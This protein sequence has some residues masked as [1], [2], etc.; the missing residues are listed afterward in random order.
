MAPR[1]KAADEAATPIP[2]P[3]APGAPAL[4]DNAPDAGEEDTAAL[5]A[6]AAGDDAPEIATRDTEGRLP[7]GDDTLKTATGVPGPMRAIEVGPGETGVL[8][9]TAPALATIDEAPPVLTAEQIENIRLKKRVLALEAEVTDLQ[10][11]IGEIRSQAQAEIDHLN[12]RIAG[13]AHKPPPAPVPAKDPLREA[14]S[15]GVLATW[16]GPGMY[17]GPY[18]TTAGVQMPHAMGLTIG[19]FPAADIARSPEQFKAG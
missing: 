13:S 9:N 7:P 17:G 1:K 3:G 12:E 2:A 19:Y 5:A 15:F 6:I 14:R 18:Y 10:E 8:D 4:P 16:L 11:R